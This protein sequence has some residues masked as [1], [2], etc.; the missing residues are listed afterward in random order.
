MAWYLVKHRT[1]LLP[2]TLVWN[3]FVGYNED[4]LKFSASIF[5]SSSPSQVGL[6]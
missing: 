2:G 4:P 5:H 1:L 3:Y 6:M